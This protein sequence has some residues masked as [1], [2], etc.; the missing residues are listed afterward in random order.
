M[1]ETDIGWKM[2][3]I[4]WIDPTEK[5]QNLSGKLEARILGTNS[6]KIIIIKAIEISS[7]RTNCVF[8]ILVIWNTD[9]EKKSHR[10]TIPQFVSTPEIKSVAE[11]CSG[12][13]RRP[14]IFLSFL[15]C[16]LLKS[17]MCSLDNWEKDT[18]EPAI[19][20]ESITKKIITQRTIR[21]SKENFL[22]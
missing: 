7:K 2:K 11:S 22:I 14:V 15:V 8:V 18:F 19:I 1:Y 21:F 17:W 12:F 20:A 3:L 13:L 6:H 4:I 9:S 16:L 10:N 5:M